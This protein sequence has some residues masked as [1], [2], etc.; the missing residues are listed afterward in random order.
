MRDRLPLWSSHPDASRVERSERTDVVAVQMREQHAIEIA[1]LQTTLIQLGNQRFIL[2][3]VESR[4]SYTTARSRT[5]TCVDENELRIRL[6]NPRPHRQRIGPAWVSLQIPD[7]AERAA[8]RWA[9][10]EKSGLQLQSARRKC[11]DLHSYLMLRRLY[12]VT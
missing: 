3:Y 4:P 6:D 1:R 9:A 2:G 8:V 5:G 12:I 11:G 10:L 7:E